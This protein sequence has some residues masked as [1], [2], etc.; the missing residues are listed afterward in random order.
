M[1]AVAAGLVI[2]TALKLM[3]TLRSNP[4]GLPL[5]AALRRR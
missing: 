2:A 3:A 1:G 4:L 5:A